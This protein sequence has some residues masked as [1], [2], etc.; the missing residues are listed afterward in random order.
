M[1]MNT[2]NEAEVMETYRSAYET[3]G[4]PRSLLMAFTYAVKQ[5]VELPKW[6]TI[7][8]A[9]KLRYALIVTQN[10]KDPFAVGDSVARVL[11]L[12]CSELTAERDRIAASLEFVV[13]GYVDLFEEING[14]R[15]SHDQAVALIAFRNTIEEDEEE[16]EEERV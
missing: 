9:S 13:D 12:D 6:V 14:W 1:T 8:V 16:E 3:G 4:D 5:D 11:G 10:V 15:P 2:C 7:G